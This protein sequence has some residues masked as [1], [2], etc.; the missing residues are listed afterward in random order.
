LRRLIEVLPELN[1]FNLVHRAG[2]LRS[3]DPDASQQAGAKSNQSFCFHPI[4]ESRSGFA[5]GWF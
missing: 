1:I 3:G 2:R 5:A 4:Q